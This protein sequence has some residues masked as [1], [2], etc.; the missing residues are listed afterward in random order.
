MRENRTYG[1]EGGEPGNG[2]SPT[3]IGG[4]CSF[5]KLLYGGSHNG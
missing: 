1:S 2:R 5:G 3:P 4:N